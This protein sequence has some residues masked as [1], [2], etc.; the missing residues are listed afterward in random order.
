MDAPHRLVRD[1][2]FTIRHT[3]P[4]PVLSGNGTGTYGTWDTDTGVNPLPNVWYRYRIRVEE[5]GANTTVK[6]RVWED[7]TTEGGSSGSAPLKSNHGR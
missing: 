7:G 5:S 6:A 1:H 2:L 3:R 4:T